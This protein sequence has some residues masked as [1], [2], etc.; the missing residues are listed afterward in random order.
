VAL[1]D[2]AS[3]EI[4]R[5]TCLRIEKEKRTTAGCKHWMDEL[6]AFIDWVKAA[7]ENTRA[8]AQ[9]QE[10]LWEKNPVSNPGQ[11]NISVAPAI[12]DESFRRWVAQ[13][14]VKDL[15]VDPNEKRSSLISFRDGLIEK[16]KVLQPGKTP[17]LKIFRVLAAFF[18]ESFTTVAHKSKL[19]QLYDR[20]GGAPGANAVESHLFI[21]ERIDKALG[22][23]DGRP[24][25]AMWRMALAWY[26]YELIDAEKPAEERTATLG[27]VAGEETLLPLSAARRRRGLTAIKGNFSTVLTVLEVVKEGMSREDLLD[28]LHTANPDHKANTSK[29]IINILRSE[30]AVIKQVDGE[31]RLTD[32]GEAILESGESSELGDWL[33]TRILGVDHVLKALQK[34]ARPRNELMD[35]LQQVNPGWTTTFAP[36]AILSWLISV[37]AIQVAADGKLVLTALG[38]DWTAL[39]KW[40]PEF[41]AAEPETVIPAVQAALATRPARPTLPSLDAVRATVLSAGTYEPQKIEQLHLGLW[42]PEIR[43]FAVLTGISGSGKTR[44]AKHYAEAL[45]GTTAT[46]A[47]SRIHIEAVQPAWY[48]PAP[49]LGYV[50][51]LKESSYTRTAFLNFL[52][53]ASAD[54][55][56]AYVAVLDEMNLSHP[57]QYFAPLLSAMETGGVLRFHAEGDTFDGV[58]A[59][60]LYPAN[61][62][63][64]GTINM[65]ETTHGLSDKVLDRAFTL[66]FSS[67]DMADYP[68]W[69]SRA[70]S[71]DIRERITAVLTALL[72]TLRP[73]RLHFGW[74]VVDDVVDFVAA[75][76]TA[77]AS[78]GVNGLLDAAIY[79]KVLPKLRGDDSDSFRKAIQNVE[80]VLK[81]YELQRSQDRVSDLAA[82][83]RVAGSARFWR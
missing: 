55:T 10:R 75:G 8:S 52:L 82:D 12:A 54:P 78:G 14:S 48:D 81:K 5:E 64:I 62:A 9:F 21:R 34:G 80:E 46:E 35:L 20:M 22:P 53:Q 59:F 73:V 61:L 70:V 32:R 77:S 51:P 42:S 40:E 50:S 68:G 27:P 36:Q 65:D 2:L 4:F 23:T 1:L 11:G 74:R 45:T 60:I 79:A 49:L 28:Y 18:P 31:Y 7:D 13:E 39:I 37:K 47:S 17:H 16:L 66:E 30:L 71:S 15:P 3:A 69:S 57:E 67:V 38:A 56:H 25:E 29:T 83:L 63:I 19:R 41:L 43:H 6:S 24:D 44:L 33:I 26:L 72:T 76:V 58:P